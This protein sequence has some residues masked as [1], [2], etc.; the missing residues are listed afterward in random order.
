MIEEVIINRGVS[1]IDC[2]LCSQYSKI[3]VFK[4]M[5]KFMSQNDVFVA[6]TKEGISRVLE[7]DYVF[8]LESSWNEFYNQRDCRLMQIGRLLDSKGYGIGL[9]QGMHLSIQLNPY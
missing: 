6:N 7:G 1:N 4:K 3:P 9:K 2:L 5:W 8:V